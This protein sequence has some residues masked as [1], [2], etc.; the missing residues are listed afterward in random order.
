[1]ETSSEAALCV[2][3]FLKKKCL[4]L[5][6][7]MTIFKLFCINKIAAYSLYLKGV[8]MVLVV[9]IVWM[10]CFNSACCLLCNLLLQV[11]DFELHQTFYLKIIFLSNLK[12]HWAF[13][14][15]PP[16][17]KTTDS[18]AALSVLQCKPRH[19]SFFILF[20]LLL[21]WYFVY[22]LHI[23]RIVWISHGFKFIMHLC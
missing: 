5:F 1:M 9:F 15:M 23:A 14:A 10:I 3:S 8:Q 13:P 2:P 6:F 4:Q 11:A 12:Q 22:C 18:W 16:L 19:L 20:L 21:L 7:W 17:F